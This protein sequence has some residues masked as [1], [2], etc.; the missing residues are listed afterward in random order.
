MPLARKH[1]ITS[2]YV[3]SATS[4][5]V[6]IKFFGLFFPL[7]LFVSLYDEMCLCVW[8]VFECLVLCAFPLNFISFALVS[9]CMRLS[10][11]VDTR[12][13][14]ICFFPSLHDVFFG[15][16]FLFNT[17]L[18]CPAYALLLLSVCGQH[19]L[20]NIVWFSSIWTIF[21]FVFRCFCLFLF[22]LHTFIKRVDW[23]LSSSK[24]VMKSVEDT[25]FASFEV[26]FAL[27][28]KLSA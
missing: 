15:S 21:L 4:T 7:P 13:E 11:I 9:K 18:D 1:M 8:D 19:Q 14:A 28:C 23:E 27:L 22:V 25:Q 3:C 12:F 5:N 16:P 6:I 26:F 10:L 17:S 2:L 20:N 24:I